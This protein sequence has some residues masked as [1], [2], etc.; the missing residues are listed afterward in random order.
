V[1]GAGGLGRRLVD[2][3]ARPV[4]AE[5][6]A[7]FRVLLGTV[8]FASV[9]VSLG[10]QLDL[11]LGPDGLYPSAG[12]ADW[13][14]SRGRFSLLLGPSGIPFLQ[15]WLPGR[16]TTAWA[17]WGADYLNVRVLFG[18]WLTALACVA[19][20]LASRLAAAVAWL[21]TV[22]FHNRL[23]WLLNGGD[24]LLCT[25]LFYLMLA[26]A[27]AAMSLDRLLRRPG[28]ARPLIPAWPVRL[29]Q[30][31]LCL[32]YLGTGLAK[33]ESDWLRGEAAYWVL[34]DLSL[35]RWSYCLLP[36]PLF[37]CRLLSWG[38]VAFELGFPVFVLL[39][40]LRPWVLAAGVALHAGIWLTTEVGWFSPVVL[41]WYA[42]FLAPL[43]PRAGV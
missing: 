20:G 7:L 26:P 38:T 13:C 12:L 4:R 31:Q 17:A 33:L 10:P 34:N 8:G 28:A 5:P 24:F 21:L 23:W 41:C 1:N 16:W 19:L 35:S 40:R 14:R 9:L 11:F 25:G 30:I 18:L 2:F 37:V 22:S 43:F 6:L 39:P 15:D 42:L 29:M 3:W 27:G 32:L 36:V